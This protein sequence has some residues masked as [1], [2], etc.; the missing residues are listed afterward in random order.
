MITATIDVVLILLVRIGNVASACIALLMEATTIIWAIVRF[1]AS[2]CIALLMEATT[3][4]W[5][6]VGFTLL[7]QT[8]LIIIYRKDYD[9]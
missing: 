9:L 4:I 2:A 8:I 6:I 5:A 7:I 3:I 1:V